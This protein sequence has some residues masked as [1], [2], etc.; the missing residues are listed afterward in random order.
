MMEAIDH[1]TQV[2]VLE[3]NVQ[4][5]QIYMACPSKEREENLLEL[6]DFKKW[7]F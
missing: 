7:E 4:N 5:C 2:R 3:A 6:V 1:F